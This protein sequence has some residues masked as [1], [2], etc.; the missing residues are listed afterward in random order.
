LARVNCFALWFAAATLL[1][2]ACEAGV[3]ATSPEAV[4]AARAEPRVTAAVP[5]EAHTLV[6]MAHRLEAEYAS[7]ARDFPPM[8]ADPRESVSPETM[9]M[10]KAAADR[11]A[12][13]YAANAD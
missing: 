9:R 6:E 1:L 12:P 5:V 10:M 8:A 3:P 11:L 4:P 13:A 2:G 7:G